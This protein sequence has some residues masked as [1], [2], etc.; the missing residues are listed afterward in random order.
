LKVTA[1]TFDTE[2]TGRY[3]AGKDN[4]RTETRW[5]SFMGDVQTLNATVASENTQI[6]FDRPPEDY[7]LLNSQQLNV[8]STPTPGK[9]SAARNN[10]IA[11]NEAQAK[12]RNETIKADVITYDSQKDLFYA[13][14]E[15]DRAVAVLQQ[16]SPGQ[17]SSSGLMRALKYNRKTGQSEAIRPM[18]AMEFV[19]AKS[20]VRP[21]PAG[22]AKSKKTKTPRI[23]PGLK[24]PVRSQTERKGMTGR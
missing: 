13:Y 15:G 24:I 5:A 10:L 7:V 2:M 16:S 19:D 1:I 8:S 14:A 20:G 9:A 22:E 18:S 11:V 12:T 21:G 23:G 3:V 17:Q 6:D 4:D